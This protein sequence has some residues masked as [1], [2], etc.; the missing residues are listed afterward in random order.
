MKTIQKGFTLIELMIVVAIIGILA[1]I[2]I[3][4]YQDYTIR[5][6]VTE[7]LNLAAPR[8]P[9]RRSVSRNT[10]AFPADHIELAF[11][12]RHATIS[13][14]VRARRSASTNGIDHDHLRQRRRTP[15]IIEPRRLI[16]TPGTSTQRRRG[17]GLRRPL[18]RR[19]ALGTAA[20]PTG[21]GTLPPKYRPHVCRDGDLRSTLRPS[22]RV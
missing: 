10:G 16:L 8:R 11:G 6:Q 5:S 14:Q 2:A 21:T 12:G 7:G 3:P 13:G 4:A 20:A 17:L 15:T 1:A 9:G 19:L 18:P 22:C